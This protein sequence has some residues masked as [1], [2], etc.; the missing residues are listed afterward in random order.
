MRIL[1]TMAVLPAAILLVYVYRLDPVEKEP[2][3]MLWGL[4]VRGMVSV[5]PAIV[6]E[7]LASQALFGGGEP[8]TVQGVLLDDL[9]VVALTE[10]GCKL[11][12]LATRSWRDPNFDY[13]F[14]GIVYAVFVGLGF[15]IAE[16]VMYVLS[17][18]PA[19]AVTRA[20]TA[21]PGHCVFAVLMGY[22]YGHARL[23]AARGHSVRCAA[24]GILCYAVPVLCHGT[25]DTLAT[26][27]D[28]GAF[29]MA[30]VAM[31]LVAMRLTKGTAK[32]A[33]RVSSY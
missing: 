20:F 15:A 17:Y 25:Y 28:E 27:G 3:S 26:I 8:S 9:V 16:N 24:L 14:D 13:V 12:F 22:F 23:A 32:R 5:V 29:L 2:A 18:G 10:E 11:L 19:V 1:L 30:L 4:L 21:I 33:E 31:A 7:T 6:I